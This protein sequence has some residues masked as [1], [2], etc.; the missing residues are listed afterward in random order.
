MHPIVA[1][2]APG[3][4]INGCDRRR[5]AN[6]HRR[7]H[8][9]RHWLGIACC[10]AGLVEDAAGIDFFTN[11]VRPYFWRSLVWHDRHWRDRRRGRRRGRDCPRRCRCDVS[12]H[13]QPRAPHL[14]R[15]MGALAD[16]AAATFRSPPGWRCSATSSPPPPGWH[17]AQLRG[18]V[19]LRSSATRRSPRGTPRC[20]RASIATGPDA[21]RTRLTSTGNACRSHWPRALPP[22]W[23][24]PEMVC[25]L[26]RAVHPAWP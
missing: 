16:R 26:P 7:R 23:L 17:G 22:A 5:P 2:G 24:S 18:P 19:V 3:Q 25:A 8:Q 6:H 10:R 12:P 11:Y 4:P 20:G 14:L 1:S 21:G 9:L 13:A 15:R